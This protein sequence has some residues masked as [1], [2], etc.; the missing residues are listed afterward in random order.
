MS[1]HRL[2]DRNSQILIHRKKAVL[3][4]SAFSY[5]KTKPQEF[6]CG[7]TKIGNKYLRTGKISFPLTDHPHNSRNNSFSFYTQ[8]N[9]SEHHFG[10]LM[11]I[12]RP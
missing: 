7:S 11:N 12:E 5:N 9:E 6:T 1:V 8:I 3:T 4:G 2:E 10:C